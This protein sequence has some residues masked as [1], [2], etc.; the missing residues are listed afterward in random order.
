MVH[1]PNKKMHYLFTTSLGSLK[2]QLK[3]LKKTSTK[4]E[5]NKITNF[6]C[7]ILQRVPLNFQ[8]ENCACLL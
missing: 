2:I 6:Y 8:T 4:Q 1:I 3:L 5:K 7:N